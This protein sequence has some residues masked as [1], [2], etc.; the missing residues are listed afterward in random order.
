MITLE[1]NYTTPTLT[2][3]NQISEKYRL[4]RI[5]GRSFSNYHK[6]YILEKSRYHVDMKINL[7]ILYSLLKKMKENPDVPVG[8]SSTWPVNYHEVFIN[9]HRNERRDDIRVLCNEL[10]LCYRR[11]S[12]SS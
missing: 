6:Q 11:C 9:K 8:G 3:I 2:E 12:S 4:L 5:T 1:A 10:S 7:V